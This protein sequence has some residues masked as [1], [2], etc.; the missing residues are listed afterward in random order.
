MRL[1][2]ALVVHV[3]LPLVSPSSL[4]M[5]EKKQVLR[6]LGNSQDL[7]PRTFMFQLDAQRSA[8]L[9][10]QFVTSNTGRGGRRYLWRMASHPAIAAPRNH[11]TAS[12]SFANSAPNRT[13]RARLNA[14]FLPHMTTSKSPPKKKDAP[15]TMPKRQS[16]NIP[17][18]TIIGTA[19]CSRSVDKFFPRYSRTRL[20][21]LYQLLQNGS[22]HEER[23]AFWVYAIVRDAT[24]TS[25][26]WQC[27]ML[28][29]SF[30]P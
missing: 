21:G 28:P 29:I 4:S 14:Q 11:T 26:L 16:T 9:R 5:V 19:I 7:T 3:G 15:T 24:A 2:P 22:G 17:T 30:G 18:L 6:G 27:S 10:S 25:S 12:T 23:I 1:T 8:S 13:T 20:Q